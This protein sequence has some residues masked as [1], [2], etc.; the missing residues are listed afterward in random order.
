MND[1]TPTQV[2]AVTGLL[3]LI[4]MAIVMLMMVLQPHAS[5]AG[6]QSRRPVAVESG[7]M[8]LPTEVQHVD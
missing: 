7:S 5:A 2:A 6:D 4:V 3:A 8:Q 1:I